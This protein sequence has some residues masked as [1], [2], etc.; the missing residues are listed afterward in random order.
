MKRHRVLEMTAISFLV[1][2]GLAFLFLPRETSDAKSRAARA[3]SA[4]GRRAGS[5]PQR[6]RHSA[7][8]HWSAID[9]REDGD[10]HDRLFQ[11]GREI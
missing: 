1:V 6:Q 9:L 2:S 7:R 8:G 4:S 11:R 10:S 3:S 5:R